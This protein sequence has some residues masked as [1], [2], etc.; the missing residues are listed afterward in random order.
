VVD[1]EHRRLPRLEDH[2]LPGVQGVVQLERAVDEHGPHAVRVREQFG[3][4]GLHVRLTPVVDLDEQGVLLQERPLDLL[5]EDGGVE[6]VLDADAHPV[7]LVRVGGAD[8]AAGGADL[9]L[10]EEAL[11]HPVHGAV[12]GRDDV[13]VG[14]D[15]Q[16]GDVDAARREVR[17]LV[18][19]HLEV[20]HDAVP[21]DGGD[22]GGEDAAGEEVEGVLLVPDHHRVA[23]VVATVE[24]DDVVGGGP[25]LV[26]RLPL[27]LVPPLGPEHHHGRHVR[28]L[29]SRPAPVGAA[30]RLPSP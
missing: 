16:P 3:G 15:A 4:H 21:D 12:V 2:R 26:G 20:H 30:P 9:P 25:E 23:G 13:G 24:L 18:E 5:P 29:H 1:V 17:Q 19:E 6:E 27:A 10:A 22:P 7:H 14:A 8:A 11:H 28:P